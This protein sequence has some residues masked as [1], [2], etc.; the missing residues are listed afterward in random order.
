MN[1]EELTRE[2]QPDNGLHFDAHEFDGLRE[3]WQQEAEGV[4]GRIDSFIRENPMTC[5]LI[6][7]AAGFAIASAT[8]SVCA[9]R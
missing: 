1:T 9:R 6:A 5:M 7:A 8:S 3:A 4:V 2:Q